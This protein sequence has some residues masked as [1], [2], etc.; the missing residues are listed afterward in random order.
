MSN[1]IKLFEVL[2]PFP[3]T[4]CGKCCRNIHLNKSLSYLDKG[5]GVCKHLNESSNLC[6]IY[7]ER[8]LVCR[9]EDYYRQNLTS[10]FTWNE[11]VN[12][13]IEVCKRL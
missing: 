5:N 12:M 10:H 9:I 6:S 4:A 11:F 13:N 3:C 7:E 8:P 2:E 1:L